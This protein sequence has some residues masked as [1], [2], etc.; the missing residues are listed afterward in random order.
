MDERAKL[1]ALL[2][3]WMEHNREHGQEFRDWAEKAGALGEAEAAAAILLA[4][5]EMDKANE[6]LSRALR[7]LGAS[8]Q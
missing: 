5:Q 7:R 4:A 6:S 2:G 3:Y 1:R 8:V